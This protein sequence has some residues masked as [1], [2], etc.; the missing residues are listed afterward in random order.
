M[1]FEL[2]FTCLNLFLRLP[3]NSAFIPSPFVLIRLPG[4]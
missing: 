1:T 2:A 4:H 3:H